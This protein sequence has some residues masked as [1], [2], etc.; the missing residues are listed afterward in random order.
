M[1]LQYCLCAIVSS[2]HERVG[3]YCVPGLLVRK[4]CCREKLPGQ[5]SKQC[6]AVVVQFHEVGSSTAYHEEKVQTND[7]DDMTNIKSLICAANGQQQQHYLSLRIRCSS[8]ATD[9]GASDPAGFAAQ[10]VN[11]CAFEHTPCSEAWSE[12]VPVEGSNSLT[13]KTHQ[14]PVKG[15]Q[16]TCSCIRPQT[17]TG[18]SAQGGI[19][20]TSNHM[21]VSRLAIRYCGT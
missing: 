5:S 3:M 18:D 20:S 8:E 7:L 1:H 12:A 14:V 6:V 17:C 19:I 9:T 2:D 16:G 10:E 4:H 15:Q 13:I 11:P 21:A